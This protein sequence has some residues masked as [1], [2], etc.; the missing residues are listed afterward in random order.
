MSNQSDF[1]NNGYFANGTVDLDVYTTGLNGVNIRVDNLSSTILY[2]CTALVCIIIFGTRMAQQAH[3]HIRHVT[4]FASTADQQ[5]Y[6]KQDQNTWWPWIK[7][8]LIYAPLK[9]KRHNREIQLTR[10]VGVGTIPGRLH[11]IVL[12]LFLLSNVVYCLMLDYSGPNAGSAIAEFRGRTGHLSCMNM[13]A[14]FILAGRNNPLIQILKVSFDTMNLFHRWI[15]RVVVLEAVAHTVAWAVNKHNARGMEGMSSAIANEPFLQ[16]GLLATVAMAVIFF[17]APSAIRHAAYET[18]LV[19]HQFLALAA[20]VGVMA[21]AKLGPLPQVPFIIFIICI[22][23]YDRLA[24]LFRLVLRN[25][26]IRKG[27]TRVTVEA[28]PGEACRVTFHLPKPWT[29]PPGAHVYAYLPSISYWQSHPFSVA[30]SETTHRGT[31]GSPT[32]NSFGSA[33]STPDSISAEKDAQSQQLQEPPRSVSRLDTV[34]HHPLTAYPS[35]V[36]LVMSA[37]TGMTRKLYERANATPLKTLHLTGA[38]EGPYGSLESLHS[39]GTI[40]L[41]AGG[42]G[43]THMLP[44]LRDLLTRHAAGPTAAVRKITLVWSIRNRD[45]LEWVRPWMEEILAMES[46][47]EVLEI[48]IFISRPKS[49]DDVI[50]PSPRVQLFAGRARTTEMVQQVFRD[51]VGAMTVGVCGGGAF[52]DDVRRAARD[53]VGRGKVDFWEEAFTW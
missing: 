50:S 33:P 9:H 14:L 3:A 18:F 19:I 5:R 38:I 51:R 8:H 17:Q 10:A 23:S 30:W 21:H 29:P 25:F 11:T 27:C 48:M 32:T 44:H 22:W 39:Y 26:T 53:C 36:S 52:S 41:F 24:R 46:R 40:L 13:I 1:V 2:T 16:W 49:K 20:L 37:H 34:A 6:W 31:L 28:L 43:I 35:H 12:V 47:R 42:V 7:E 4:S 45:C 15:G